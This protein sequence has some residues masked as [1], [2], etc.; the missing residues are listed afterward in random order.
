LFILYF[1]KAAGKTFQ[2]GSSKLTLKLFKL[3]EL[4]ERVFFAGIGDWE[5]I[6]FDEEC[7][8]LEGCSK[9]ADCDGALREISCSVR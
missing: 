9:V 2:A 8:G 7:D 6:L 5:L 3:S 4:S 1:F